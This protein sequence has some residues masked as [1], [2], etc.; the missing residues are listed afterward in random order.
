MARDDTPLAIGPMPEIL[1][2]QAIPL[3]LHGVNPRSIMSRAA[4]DV[5]RR[6]IYARHGHRCA[7]CGTPSRAAIIL[8][9][10][11]AHERFEIDFRKREMRLIGMEPLCHACH[12]FV[13]GGLMQVMLAQRM[14]PSATARRILEHGTNVLRQIGGRVPIHAHQLCTQLGL[15][16]GLKVAKAPPASGWSGWKLI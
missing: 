6:E 4:W 1:E 8:Q 10:L 3:P 11:E 5:M 15:R 13:H 16:H 2:Q 12:R 14:L 9:R 7:A